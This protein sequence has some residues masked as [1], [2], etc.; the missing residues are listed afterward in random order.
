MLK[1]QMHG[2]RLLVSYADPA[3]GQV[4]GIY[5][6]MGWTYVGETARDYY[7]LDHA[8]RRWHRRNVSPTG[9]KLNF[10]RPTWCIRP[11]EGRKVVVPGERKYL[12]PLDAEMRE[13]ITPLAWPYPKPPCKH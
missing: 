3:Q 7:I 11:S 13:R 12:W 6:A 8:R 1:R 10:G 5:Q 4:G 2:L 9:V